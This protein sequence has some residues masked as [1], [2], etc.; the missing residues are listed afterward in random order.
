MF[1]STP[2]CSTLKILGVSVL[3]FF[4]ASL[5]AQNAEENNKLINNYREISL[6]DTD[7]GVKDFD[8]SDFNQDGKLDIVI[9]NLMTHTIMCFEYLSFG[10]YKMHVLTET[11][12]NVSFLGLDDLDGD[13]IKEIVFSDEESIGYFK[14]ESDFKFKEITISESLSDCWDMEFYDYDGDGD[15]DILAAS[16]VINSIFWLENQQGYFKHNLVVDSLDAVKSIALIDVNNDSRIDV[17]ACSKS[18]QHLELFIQQDSS[19]TRQ[20]ICKNAYATLVQVG[21]VNQDGAIDILCAPSNSKEFHIHYNK[22]NSEFDTLI[23]ERRNEQMLSNIEIGDWN[24]DGYMD[25]FVNDCEGNN[26]IVFEQNEYGEFEQFLLVKGQDPH[27][28]KLIDIDGDKDVDILITTV[29]DGNLRMLENNSI[30]KWSWEKICFLVKR[31]GYLIYT[32]TSLLLVMLLLLIRFLRKGVKMD[33]SLQWKDNQIQNLKH[34]ANSQELININ[35]EKMIGALQ[36]E[37][38]VNTISSIRW[39]AFLNEYQM[40]NP[41]FCDR[42]NQNNLT[43]SEFRLAVFLKSGLTSHEISEILSV[44]LKTVYVQRQRLKDKLNLESTKELESYLSGL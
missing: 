9:S 6:I 20:V 26:T 34:R 33:T 13:G 19:Y 12:N 10:E 22:G 4:S 44:N 3:C 38:R 11:S 37:S 5:F 41:K 25:L 15:S 36:S 7:K 14:Y 39:G 24:E 1:S 35:Q 16:R 31:S 23:L 21:D 28:L 42:L 2:H 30:E 18:M 43:K 8:L 27:G 32:Y 40:V 17:L 29:F